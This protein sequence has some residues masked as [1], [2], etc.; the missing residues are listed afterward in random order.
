VQEKIREMMRRR[1]RQLVEAY[2]AGTLEK[3]APPPFEDEPEADEDLSDNE[4]AQP[5]TRPADDDAM[6]VDQGSQSRPKT[7][8]GNGGVDDDEEDDDEDEE[9]EA[10]LS[11]MDSRGV[12][13]AMFGANL[14]APQLDEDQLNVLQSMMGGI[15]AK[16]TGAA[17]S[18]PEIPPS[19]VALPGEDMFAPYDIL[20]GF[21]DDDD[22][23]W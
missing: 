23:G 11:R 14:S 6:Q 21:D 20:G 17:A 9:D 4:D 7:N 15:T 3:D 5:P 8:Q 22:A 16:R 19:D 13:N 18:V 2:D 10:D 12:S 1:V